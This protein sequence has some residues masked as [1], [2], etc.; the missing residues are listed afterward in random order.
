MARRGGGCAGAVRLA[1]ARSGFVG[2][3]PLRRDRENDGGPES[4]G[5]SGAAG[6]SGARQVWMSA[7]D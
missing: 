6:N 1:S 4:M 3:H 2:Y 7:S 5:G